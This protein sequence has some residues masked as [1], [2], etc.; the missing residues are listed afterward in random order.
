ML[1]ERKK[2]KRPKLTKNLQC[3]YNI[4]QKLK[5]YYA[6]LNR[7]ATTEFDKENSMQVKIST[8]LVVHYARWNWLLK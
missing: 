6:L 3:I 5:K 2:I 4:L 1:L 8:L 7:L